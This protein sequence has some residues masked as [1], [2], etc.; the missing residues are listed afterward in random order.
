MVDIKIV[1][2]VKADKL[3]VSCK[4]A[5]EIQIRKKYKTNLVY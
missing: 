1:V 5:K 2:E 3:Q 4:V